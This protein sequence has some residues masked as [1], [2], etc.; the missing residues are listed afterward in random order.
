[1]SESTCQHCGNA[2]HWSYAG[3]AGFVHVETGQA[4]CGPVDWHALAEQ[5]AAL[6]ARAMRVRAKLDE[7]G[8]GHLWD[9]VREN[10]ADLA[11]E[12]PG[13]GL[14]DLDSLAYWQTFYGQLESE[15]DARGLDVAG[16]CVP[17][18]V[19]MQPAGPPPTAAP[20]QPSTVRSVLASVVLPAVNAMLADSVDAVAEGRTAIAVLWEGL[21]IDADMYRGYLELQPGG[22]RTRRH[23]YPPT[24]NEGNR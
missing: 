10:L 5:R 22:D 18:V 21:A 6:Q 20:L 12:R 7:I 1:M 17:P 16:I 4:E 9:A 13:E 14:D 2:V 11:V 23:Y 15:A 3:T 24:L 19:K 8:E